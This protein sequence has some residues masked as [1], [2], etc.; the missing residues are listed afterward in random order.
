[1]FRVLTIQNETQAFAFL[2][3]VWPQCL[4]S[5]IF[6]WGNSQHWWSP[7]FQWPHWVNWGELPVILSMTADQTSLWDKV[8]EL[9]QKAAV[10]GSKIMASCQLLSSMF[11][12]VFSH[13][14]FGFPDV[15]RLVYNVYWSFMT[16]FFQPFALWARSPNVSPTGISKNGGIAVMDMEREI[17]TNTTIIQTGIWKSMK[18]TVGRFGWGRKHFG[19]RGILDDFGRHPV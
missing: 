8:L 14:I 15:S 17:I 3:I 19:P 11:H 2:P 10:S 16:F 13:L 5:P 4:N 7:Y 9:T 12:V 18:Y 6:Q 1:M